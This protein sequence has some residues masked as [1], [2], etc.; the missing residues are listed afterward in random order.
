M[1]LVR[2]TLGQVY[3]TSSLLPVELCR[4]SCVPRVE[5]SLTGQFHENKLVCKQGLD[6]HKNIQYN[7]TGY[8]IFLPPTKQ[9]KNN[10]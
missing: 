3:Y 4:S 2:Y 10:K 7:T 1:R 8:L 9:K 5:G 6:F